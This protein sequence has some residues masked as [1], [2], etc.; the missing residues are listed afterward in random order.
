[1]WALAFQRDTVVTA[2]KIAIVVGLIL[3]LINQGDV[4]L[5]GEFGRV[6]WTKFAVTF[7][8]PYS[9]STYTNVV[10]QLKYQPGSMAPADARLHCDACGHTLAIKKQEFVPACDHCGGQSWSKEA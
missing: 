1:M 7:L 3:N 9:V 10:S 8:V 4:L 5:A 6:S 2:L